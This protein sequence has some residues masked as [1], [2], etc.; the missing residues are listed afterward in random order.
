MVLYLFD[1]SSSNIGLAFLKNRLIFFPDEIK[2]IEKC[3]K[4]MGIEISNILDL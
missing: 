3:N 1:I 4:S 2:K